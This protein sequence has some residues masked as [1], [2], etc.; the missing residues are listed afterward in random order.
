MDLIWAYLTNQA[1]L[2]DDTNTER[3][4]RKTMSYQMVNGTL[5]KRGRNGI[6]LKCITQTEGISLLHDIHGEIC[7]SYTSRRTLVRKAF[8]QRFYWPAVLEDATVAIDTF[9]KWVEAEPQAG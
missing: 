8:R 5:Y 6:L 3:T 9:T 2:V 7:G 1:T 4:S